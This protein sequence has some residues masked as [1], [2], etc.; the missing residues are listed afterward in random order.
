QLHGHLDHLISP[1]PS[2]HQVTT[3][4]HTT[5]MRETGQPGHR[6][7]SKCP[8]D[9]HLRGFASL[10]AVSY[11]AEGIKNEAERPICG[12]GGRWFESTQLYQ[13]S[14]INQQLARSARLSSI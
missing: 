2:N 6:G 5:G 10:F 4:Y 9:A 1:V 12:S 14:T 11:G 7:G 8:S 3:A 13:L